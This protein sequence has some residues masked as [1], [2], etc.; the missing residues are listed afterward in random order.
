MTH[1]VA[2]EGPCC[3]GK[4]TLAEGLRALI[5]PSPLLVVP[6]Y[7]DF[8]GGGDQMPDPADGSQHRQRAALEFLLRAE[9]ARFNRWAPPVSS[10]PFGIQDRSA[11]TL[12]GHCAGLDGPSRRPGPLERL[13]TDVVTNDERAVIP[14]FVIYL[15]VSNDVQLIRNKGKFPD[16]SIFMDKVFNAGF[17]NFFC[18]RAAERAQEGL[19]IIDGD[20]RK[21]DVLRQSVG[22]LD[23]LAFNWRGL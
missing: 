23:E 6:D 18:L 14:N 10:R 3:A 22:Y 16:G 1:W 13:A 15:N 9:A 7:A 20:Q 17:E 21:Q 19:V 12:I 8:L 11:L 2:I 5:H 4:T